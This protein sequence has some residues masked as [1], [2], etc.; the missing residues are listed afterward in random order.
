MRFNMEGSSSSLGGPAFDQSSGGEVAIQWP[1]LGGVPLCRL[2][3]GGLVV[4]AGLCP[5]VGGF[6]GEAFELV[7]AFVVTDLAEQVGEG[8]E[9]AIALRGGGFEWL[10]VELGVLGDIPHVFVF[11]VVLECSVEPVAPGRAK[12]VQ[13]PHEQVPGPADEARQDPVAEAAELR[14]AAS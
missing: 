4:V 1:L 10:V 12:Q 3:F 5:S 7:D 6:G 8:R 11:G 14:P 13:C 2:R 9:G